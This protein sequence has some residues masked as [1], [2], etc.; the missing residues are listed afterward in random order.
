MRLTLT[1]TFVIFH[2]CCFS[3]DPWKN[4]YSQHAWA[5][6][7]QW[8]RP[9]EIVRLLNIQP[10]AA[11]A[12]IGCH[13]GYMTFKLAKKVG[14]DGLVYAVD[15]SASKLEKLKTRAEQNKIT[16]IKIVRGDEK[17]PNLPSNALDAVIILDTYHEMKAHEEILQHI[18]KSLRSGG[19]L[20]ICEPI[21]EMR[22][23]LSRQEQEKKHEL[24]MAHA[25]TDLTNA[26]F[27]I[28]YQKDPFLDRTK[29]K[30]D[31]M[32]VVVAV[33]E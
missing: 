16:Q 30:G 24:A 22:R 28:H 12:D 2:L 32:W 25:L 10:G 8:Q 23:K 1:L 3:Q 21:A 13:E 14:E 31:K 15:I 11:V 26:G 6:R 27:R 17:N 5:E 7:D 20:L 9:D 29:E 19:R 18:K 4:I 33:K